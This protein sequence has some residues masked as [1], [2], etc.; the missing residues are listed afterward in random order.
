MKSR[1]LFSG[2]L[3]LFMLA[4]SVVS[5]QSVGIIGDATPTGWGADTDMTKHPDSANYWTITIDMVGPGGC[6]FRQDDDWKINW[7]AKDFPEGIG[8]Q[9]GANIPIP[10]A[11]TY[12]I[13]FNATTG[14]YK[15]AVRSDIGIIGDAANGWTDDVNMYRDAADTNKYFLIISM[16][17]G[18]CKFRANDGW[19]KNWG[20]KDFPAGTGIQDGDNIPITVAGKYDVRFDKSTGAYEFKE[21]VEFNTL[22]IIGTATA[23][24]WDTDTDLKRNAANPD[25]WGGDVALTV[26]ELKFR[27]ND[28]WTINWGDSIWPA[29]IALPGGPNLKVPEAGNYRVSFN[30]KTGE[31]KFL[32]IKDFTSMGIIGTATPGGWAAD[33]DMAQDPVDKSIWRK[34]MVLKTGQAKFRAND[35]WDDNWGGAAFPT[36][37]AERDGPNIPVDTGE[38]NVTFNSISL[39]YNF[40]KLKVFASIGLVGTGTPLASWDTDVDMQKDAVDE[41]IW[42][43]PSVALQDGKVK[44]RAEDAW[45]VNWGGTTWPSGIGT[46]DGPDIVVV[47]GTYKASI[48]TLTGDYSFSDPSSTIDLLRSDVIKLF[49]NP[50]ANVVNLQIS[51]KSLQGDVVVRV[52]NSLG[53]LVST[54]NLNVQESAVP[55]KIEGMATGNYLIQISNNRFTVGK[56]LV[57][58]K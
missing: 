24:G 46:Q 45:A 58:V 27:A 52:F 4:A 7:G 55:V 29:G 41:A 32:L 56:N 42:F 49:P 8:T 19:A 44:F 57:I 25:L 31:Y 6:K 9:D 48:N 23:G 50:A 13:G 3:S 21:V 37:I 28:A 35:A 30:T 16:K 17:V 51:E 11:G 10:A 5:S 20:S 34:R 22:G 40:E 43:L 26:G 47:P 1:L 14:A 54:Q 18:G 15:F 33:T 39:E 36:G 53:T 12:D 38:Y 2:L